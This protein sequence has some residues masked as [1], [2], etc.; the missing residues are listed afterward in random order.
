[1]WLN[2]NPCFLRTAENFLIISQLTGPQAM[3][4][5]HHFSHQT[6]TLTCSSCTY[7]CSE[8]HVAGAS[9][10]PGVV[11]VPYSGGQNKMVPFPSESTEQQKSGTLNAKYAFWSVFWK[12][13]CTEWVGENNKGSNRVMEGLSEVVVCRLTCDAWTGE[14]QA[15]DRGGWVGKHSRQRELHMLRP[16]GRVEEGNS[17]LMHLG[18]WKSFKFSEYHLYFKI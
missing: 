3:A 10:V 12:R 4:M 14:G 15:K 5:P 11:L 16:H 2:I 9:S 18:Q 7:I 17:T 13:S 6:P 1:M 8:E